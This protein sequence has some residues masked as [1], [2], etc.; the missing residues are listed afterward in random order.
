MHSPRGEKEPFGKLLQI[1]GIK[2]SRLHRLEPAVTVGFGKA[3]A[4]PGAVIDHQ[5][6]HS[7]VADR[8][9]IFVEG[10]VVDNDRVRAIPRVFMLLTVE[11]QCLLHVVAAMQ[12]LLGGRPP[13]IA[14]R[15]PQDAM[16]AEE[17]GGHQPSFRGLGKAISIATV[18]LVFA[19]ATFMPID[20]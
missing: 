16:G 7:S 20:L 12:H 15:H 10:L 1:V 6:G 17:A 11:L 14:E 13:V 19:T 4:A 18:R 2:A 3:R 8:D 5:I 9:A